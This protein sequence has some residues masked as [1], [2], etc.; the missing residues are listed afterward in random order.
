MKIYACNITQLAQFSSRSYQYFLKKVI[1]PNGETGEEKYYIDK[2]GVRHLVISEIVT[3]T[4]QLYINVRQSP[5]L[6]PCSCMNFN[7]VSTLVCDICILQQSYTQLKNEK[8]MDYQNTGQ[9]KLGTLPSIYFPSFITTSIRITTVILI[10]IITTS[11]SGT[12]KIFHLKYIRYV[13]LFQLKSSS[14]KLLCFIIGRL[15]HLES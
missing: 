13:L 8:I 14:L 15:F 2:V 11:I 1:L 5:R 6:K 7:F 3:L 9:G 10:L 4:Y 12:V